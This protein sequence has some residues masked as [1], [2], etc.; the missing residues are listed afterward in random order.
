MPDKPSPQLTLARLIVQEG[1]WGAYQ[2]G[3]NPASREDIEKFFDKVIAICNAESSFNPNAV[4]GKHKG[5][6]QINTELHKDIIAGRNIFDP[7]VNINVAATVSRNAFRNG[8][9]QFQPWTSYTSKSPRYL[10]SKGWGKR[11]YNYVAE[12]QG[13]GSAGAD[14]GGD[15]SGSGNADADKGGLVDWLKLPG[16]VGSAAVS[17]GADW[18]AA[19]AGELVRASISFIKN[20]GPIIGIFLLGLFALSFGLYLLV[21]NTK[22]GSDVISDAKTGVKLAATKGIVK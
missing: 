2:R 8:Q 11:A 9:D 22:V 15:S 21:K 7:L 20:A 6:F 14:T 1:S 12:V 13:S 10:T 5:L 18:T 19:S 3:P 17:S 16:A 4:N